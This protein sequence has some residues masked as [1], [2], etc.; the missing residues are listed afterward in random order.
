[1]RE[2]GCHSRTAMPGPAC[3]QGEVTETHHPP[4]R[5]GQKRR[6]DMKQETMAPGTLDVIQ[7]RTVVPKIQSGAKPSGSPSSLPPESSQPWYR[8]RDP[9]R[10]QQ[11]LG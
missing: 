9:G 5:K 3:S 10:A 11:T 8:K 6:Q 1:M 2:A 4:P 7:Q